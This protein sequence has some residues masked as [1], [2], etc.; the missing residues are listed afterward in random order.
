M[1]RFFT[2]DPC[3][4]GQICAVTDQE[5]HHITNVVRM[6]QG[7]YI[8]LCNGD[9]FDYTAVIQSVG[10]TVLAL[11]TS[12]E[13]SQSEPSTRIT[14]YQGL[15]KG[16]KMEELFTRC[17]EAGVS[18]FVP[19]HCTRSVVK[20]DKKDADKKLDRLKK[21]VLSACKQC[22]RAFL[23]SVEAPLN[24]HQAG[25]KQHQ[26]KLV[27]YE[28]ESAVSLSTVIKNTDHTDIAVF[29]GPEGGI[30]KDELAHLKAN[31]WQ[32]VSLGK[33]ILRT[34]NAGFAAAVLILG[35]KGDM[36]AKE[37]SDV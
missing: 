22:G 14:L 25:L 33:R 6:Q 24:T 18:G 7:Q 2:S 23:P 3:A 35:L 32:S 13:K 16:D 34:E 12:A 11:I 9:G 19:V 1:R 36:D 4:V 31:G 20:W 27:A 37:G 28:D 29:I 17:C 21:H 8:I 15:A 26:L 5:A 10:Q 30:D